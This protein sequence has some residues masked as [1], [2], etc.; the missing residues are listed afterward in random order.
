[1]DATDAPNKKVPAESAA[2]EA[3]LAAA[4]ATVELLETGGYSFRHFD[5]GLL[6]PGGEGLARAPLALAVL[7]PALGALVAPALPVPGFGLKL[8]MSA[9]IYLPAAMAVV[10]ALTLTRVRERLAGQAADPGRSRLGL[11]ATAVAL[12]LAFFP[13]TMVIQAVTFRSF[14]VQV[15]VTVNLVLGLLV[16]WVWM[17]VL[18]R[19]ALLGE[20]G[21]RSLALGVADAIVFGLR[22]VAELPYYPGLWWARL[23]GREDKRISA[24]DLVASQM[25]VR[26]LSAVGSG[27]V[28]VGTMVLGLN[29]TSPEVGLPAFV[30]LSGQALVGALALQLGLG[31]WAFYRLALAAETGPGSLEAGATALPEPTPEAAS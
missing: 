17:H 30:Y 2:R 12:H 24:V 21:F 22:A 16:Q 9:N 23:Q 10:G 26:G 13:V 28:T 20:G 29:W 4:E 18:G 15:A 31:R 25:I 11:G 14:G 1:M 7:A 6:W 27:V 19:L 3:G 5:L 8:L